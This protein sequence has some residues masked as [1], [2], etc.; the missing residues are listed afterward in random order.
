MRYGN[1]QKV[2]RRRD[3]A[4]GRIQTN[5][6]DKLIEETAL[7]KIL[8]LEI[9]WMLYQDRL[10]IASRKVLNDQEMLSSKIF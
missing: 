2:W 5:D 10:W 3:L 6:F 7:A 8:S 1:N 9:K 4:I